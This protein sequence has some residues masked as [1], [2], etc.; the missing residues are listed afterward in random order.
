[1][2]G[3]SNYYFAAARLLSNGSLDPAFGGYNSE[4]GTMYL[5]P[6]I[7][8]GYNVCYSIVLQSDGKI[9]MGGTFY[10]YDYTFGAARLLSNGQLDVTF[11]GQSDTISETVWVPV[12][13]D[14]NED[15][16]YSIG[17]RSDGKIIMGGLTN[18]Q[19]NFGLA[20]LINPI[21]LS[22][23][24]ASYAQVGAGMYV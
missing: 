24:Q 13:K 15:F 6:Y 5:Y 1:M 19:T 18:D 17:L 22:D 20:Q 10:P 9:L 14:G 2:G 12:I 11:G 3:T 23:Y 21:T 8:Y 4:P 7:N 16:C